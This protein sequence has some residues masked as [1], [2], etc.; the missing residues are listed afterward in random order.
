MK[1]G[2]TGAATYRDYDHF[3]R[4]M[5]AITVPVTLIITGGREGTEG[6]ARRY[7]KE[8]KVSRLVHPRHTSDSIDWLCG[9]HALLVSD[10]DNLLAFQYIGSHAGAVLRTCARQAGK[11]L[12][13]VDLESTSLPYSIA[14]RY[15]EEI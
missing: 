14:A 6:M 5:Q 7:A 12:N 15:G 9:F 10:A 4:V 1:L 2:I 13:T 11:R 8:Y 3:C